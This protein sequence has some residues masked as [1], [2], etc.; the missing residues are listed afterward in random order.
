MA[1]I[2]IDFEWPRGHTYE[3][4]KA[5]GG[6]WLIRQTSKGA[7]ESFKP[8][9]IRDQ[10]YRDFAKLDGSRDA[11]LTFARSFGLLRT[12]AEEGAEERLSYWRRE[13]ERMKQSIEGLRRAF[14]ENHP[15]VAGVGAHITEIGVTLKPTKPDGKPALVFEP[16]VLIDGMRLQLAQS[17]ASGNEIHVCEE[18]GTWFEVGGGGAKRTIAR[19]CSTPCKGKFHYKQRRAG[20]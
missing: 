9:E 12:R 2:A 7:D 11:C 1:K 17:I 3:C 5:D 19:F 13:I 10:L 16:R 8:L 14:E 18:C 15:I 4:A 20:Q 6:D